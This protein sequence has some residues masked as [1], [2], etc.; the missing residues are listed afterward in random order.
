M[1]LNTPETNYKPD[2]FAVADLMPQ[3]GSMVLIDA[4]TRIDDHSISTQ[5]EVRDDQ[6][7]SQAN[8]TV[9]AWLGIEYMAQTIA[10]FSG[11]H[12]LVRSEPIRLGFLLGTRLFESH[13]ASYPCGTL[14]TVH[15]T[16]IIESANDMCVFD[17]S[18][19]IND[20]N[21]SN[22]TLVASA[23]I[24]LLLPKDLNAFLEKTKL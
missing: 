15:A 7:F 4:V 21:G 14:L 17:S 13:H 6:L 2:R 24:N 23:K 1:N 18:I 8:N 12:C 19:E 20:T 9:P 22:S 10:A 16:K 5:L 3:S 11:Y